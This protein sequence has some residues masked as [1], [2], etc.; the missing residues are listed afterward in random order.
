MNRTQLTCIFSFILA[1]GG[2]G[3]ACTAEV[4]DE[5]DIHPEYTGTGTDISGGGTGGT[6]DSGNGGTGGTIDQPD[7]CGG[8]CPDV[9]CTGNQDCAPDQFCL[10]TAPYCLFEL[11]TYC[12]PRPTDCSGEAYQPVCGCDG[13]IYA[14]E[15]EAGAAGSSVGQAT[16]PAPEG[17]VPCFVTYCEAAAEQ[18][19][20]SSCVPL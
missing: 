5:T 10:D 1:L 18:C 13:Q 15:C 3:T 2:L 17:Y 8:G 6:T 4:F 11:Q 20:G 19:V 9:Q 16:C 7:G 14:N 12:T